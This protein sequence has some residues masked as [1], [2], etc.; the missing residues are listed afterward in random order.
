MKYRQCELRRRNT[1]QVAWIP[2]S[3]AG[4]GKYLRLGGEDGWLVTAVYRG[5]GVGVHCD[6]NRD[7]RALFGS[8]A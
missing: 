1:V 8:L 5:G 4:L 6:D 7:F 3:F 2:E